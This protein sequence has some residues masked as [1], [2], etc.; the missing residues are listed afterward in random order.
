M[1]DRTFDGRELNFGVIGVDRGSLTMY[2]DATRSWWSQLFG[3]AIQGKMQGRKLVKLPSTMTTWGK[4][5]AL[6]PHTTVYVKSSIPYRHRFTQEHFGNI[7]KQREGPARPKDIALGVEGHV[8]ARAYLLRR[9]A[10]ERLRN[11]QLEGR[12]ILVFLSEDHATAR[13][14]SREV[15]GKTLT[16]EPLKD[17]RV[18]DRETGSVWDAIAGTAVSGPMNGAELAPLTTTY[19]LWDVWRR[20]R[21]DTFLAGESTE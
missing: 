16:F 9:L 11:D 1:Y 14:Y 5:K 7:A 17:D 8:E 12:P 15:D 6:H 18:R 13:A 3:E 4:W 10:K 2:D 20:Y 19:V 21:P